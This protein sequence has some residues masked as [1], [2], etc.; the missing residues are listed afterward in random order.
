MALDSSDRYQVHAFL[1]LHFI[2]E[3]CGREMELTSDYPLATD[4]WCCSVAARARLEGW[5]LADYDDIVDVG[6][7]LCPA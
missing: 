2:C 6:S 7:C 1:M 4:E 3:E 5:F